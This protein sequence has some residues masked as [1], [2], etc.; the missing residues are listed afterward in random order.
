MLDFDFARPAAA[1]ATDLIGA[2]AGGALKWTAIM[3]GE[4]EIT[5]DDLF[6]DA[7]AWAGRLRG[8][9]VSAASMH[10]GWAGTPLPPAA[11]G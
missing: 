1:V 11:D 5:F 6:G 8:T 9:G 3:D 7:D 2:E 4:G 10:P